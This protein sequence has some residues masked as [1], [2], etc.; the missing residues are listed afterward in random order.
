MYR[1][2]YNREAIENIFHNIVKAGEE[3][4]VVRNVESFE[5]ND[6]SKNVA[7]CVR[8][9]HVQTDIHWKNSKIEQNY[10]QI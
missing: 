2:I 7:K 1:G 9:N 5:Y 3:G 6:F 4:I 10:C 8:K